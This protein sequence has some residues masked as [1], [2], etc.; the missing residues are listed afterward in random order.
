MLRRCVFGLA[1]ALL[2]V[3]QTNHP[4]TLW[5]IGDSTVRNGQGNGAN[6]QWGWGDL[7]APFFDTARI[8]IANRALGGRSSRT[9]ISEG[10]WDRVREQIQPGDFVLIQFGHNDASPINDNSRARGTIRGIGQETEEIDNLLNGRHEVIHSYGWYL[11]KLIAEA[12]FEGATPMICSPVPRN[13]WRDGR[14]VREPYAAWAKSV[15]ETAAVPFVDLNE[16]IAARYEQMGSEKAG[17]LFHGD[18]THTSREGAEI[19]AR[20]AAEAL[21]ETGLG[22]FLR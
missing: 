20:I 5:I 15:A 18:H 1:F 9:F 2:T 7:I 16:R 14:V 19:N 3:A 17:A 12:Q 21:R 10:H 4:P 11:R 22:A 6:G 8:Q 13:N